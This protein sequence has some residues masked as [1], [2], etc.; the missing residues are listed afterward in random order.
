MPDDVNRV[1]Q[2]LLSMNIPYDTRIKILN[3]FD[4]RNN[5]GVSHP[6]S[7]DGIAWEVSKEE[8][9]EYHK[10]VGLCLDNLLSS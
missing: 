8:Y 7:D 1:F 5:N 3:L 10:H 6:G 2:Y 9:F 4:R